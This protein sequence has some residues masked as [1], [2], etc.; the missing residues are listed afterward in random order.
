MLR[1][2]RQ[3]GSSKSFHRYFN[4]LGTVFVAECKVRSHSGPFPQSSGGFG[5][6]GGS[7]WTKLQLG[8]WS[9]VATGLASLAEKDVGRS[10]CTAGG[11]NQG[12]GEQSA[13]CSRLLALLSD[14]IW[15]GW[16]SYPDPGSKTNFGWDRDVVGLAGSRSR[17]TVVTVALPRH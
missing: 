11:L 10:G 12:R 15:V 7:G 2:N 17:R 1:L 5:N 16:Q 9:G 6:S 13:R 4:S 8:A 14:A 3:P